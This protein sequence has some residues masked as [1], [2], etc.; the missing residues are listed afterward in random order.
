M[1][2][3]QKPMPTQ[4]ETKPTKQKKSEGTGVIPPATPLRH[5]VSVFSDSLA[6][7]STA[8]PATEFRPIT[9]VVENEGSMLRM[10]VESDPYL[11][12][13][14]AFEPMIAPANILPPTCD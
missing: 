12:S 13:R 3:N 6:F 1:R 7:A 2:Q 5:S 14:F 9:D 11:S 8:L 4:R 10:V